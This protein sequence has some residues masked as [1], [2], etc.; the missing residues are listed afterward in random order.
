MSDA[1]HVHIVEDMIPITNEEHP[2]SAALSGYAYTRVN[3]RTAFGD[4]IF[5]SSY[6]GSQMFA[7]IPMNVS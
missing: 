2:S 3:V 5:P 1:R 6:L 7:L 4:W